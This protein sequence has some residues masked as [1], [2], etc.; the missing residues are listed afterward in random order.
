MF[1]AGVLAIVTLY[2]LTPVAW[3]DPLSFTFASVNLMSQH[4]WAGCMMT[5]GQ[6]IPTHS[7][8]WSAWKYMLIWMAAQVPLLAIVGVVPASVL[9]LT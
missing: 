2:V 4:L 7:P 9:D 8:E 1:G 5:A 3:S 6:C